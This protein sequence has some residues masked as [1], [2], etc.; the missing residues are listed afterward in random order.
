MK[1]GNL[2]TNSTKTVFCLK[3][4]CHTRFS[5]RGYDEN[6]VSDFGEIKNVANNS[7]NCPNSHSIFLWYIS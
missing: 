6:F 5:R 1:T 7:M 4:S 3:K 2:K